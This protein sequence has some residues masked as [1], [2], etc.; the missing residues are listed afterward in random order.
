MDPDPGFPKGFSRYADE[1]IRHI[2]QRTL[3]RVLKISTVFV[4]PDPRL[5][6]GSG[7]FHAAFGSLLVPDP[8]FPK[9]FSRW[10]K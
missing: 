3:L 5:S 6:D 2:A 1:R 7:I 9:S 8:V 4:D 10:E